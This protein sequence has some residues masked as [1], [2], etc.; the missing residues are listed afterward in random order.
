MKEYLNQLRSSMENGLTSDNDIIRISNNLSNILAHIIKEAIKQN[1]VSESDM[2]SLIDKLEETVLFGTTEFIQ[3][4]QLW[5]ARLSRQ[6]E[7][8]A[9]VQKLMQMSNPAVIPRNHRVEEALEAAV[10]HGDYSVMEMLVDVL[11]NPYEYSDKQTEYCILPV[12]SDSS[13]RTFCGT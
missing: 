7:S 12:E 5:Q 9:S 1:K 3:W 13:Y 6:Q 10:N 2:K 11:S 4:N 8:K